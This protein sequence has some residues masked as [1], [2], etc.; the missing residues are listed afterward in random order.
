ME[1]SRY[2]SPDTSDKLPDE[3]WV[4]YWDRKRR[5]RH[6]PGCRCLLCSNEEL[7]PADHSWCPHTYEDDP[8][9]IR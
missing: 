9:V 1:Q 6:G 3:C 4:D 2:S 7:L 5:E 8:E